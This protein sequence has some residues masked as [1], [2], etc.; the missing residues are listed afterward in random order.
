MDTLGTK[1]IVLISE[2]FLF[3][4]EKEI[5]LYM[6]LAA[7]RARCPDLA[8]CSLREVPLYS[9]VPVHLVVTADEGLRTETLCNN[10]YLN[11]LFQ[12]VTV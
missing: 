12:V 7:S 9:C 1:I 6:K 3:Q 5:F 4:G 10:C 8:R 2:A 11:K